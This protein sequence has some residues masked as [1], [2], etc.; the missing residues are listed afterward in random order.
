MQLLQSIFKSYILSI[1][2]AVDFLKGSGTG[3]PFEHYKKAWEFLLW[4]SGNES[5]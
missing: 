3:A 2:E 4:H 1:L 5:N